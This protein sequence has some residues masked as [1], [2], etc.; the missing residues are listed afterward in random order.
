[1]NSETWRLVDSQ[2]LAL[3]GMGVGPGA[4]AAALFALGV[5][6]AGIAALRAFQGSGYVQPEIGTAIMV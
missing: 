1:M 3:Q 4:G 2:L 5:A 6:Q